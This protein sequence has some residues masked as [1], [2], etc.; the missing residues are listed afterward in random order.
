MCLDCAFARPRFFFMRFPFFF[1]SK[2][3]L[4]TKSSMNSA[5]VHCSWT[6]KLH[7]SQ[8]FSLKMGLTVLFT[9]L[10]IILLQYFQFSVNVFSCIQM[11]PQSFY[12]LGL[13]TKTCLY[14]CISFF[15]SITQIYLL[16]CIYL[17]LFLV[18]LCHFCL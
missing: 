16:K 2:P 5:S 9:H 3:Q 18:F 10:K 7:F 8:I 4:Q 11:N 17:P 1:F 12:F 13:G 14:N 15:S 6:H